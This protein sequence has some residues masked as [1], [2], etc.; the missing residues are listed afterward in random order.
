MN[1]FVL[2]DVSLIFYNFLNWKIV[3]FWVLK[4]QGFYPEFRDSLSHISHVIFNFFFCKFFSS[5]EL[6]NLGF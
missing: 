4:V 2:L 6:A 1:K 3:E 5:E